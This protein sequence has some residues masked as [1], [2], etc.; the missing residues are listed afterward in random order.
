MRKIASRGSVK[1]RD[2]EMEDFM[3]ADVRSDNSM[4]RR[5]KREISESFEVDFPLDGAR[6]DDDCDGWMNCD[7]A[8]TAGMC[9]KTRG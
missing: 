8:M 2:G 1:R 3:T 7:T 5:P 6:F 9:W 4:R